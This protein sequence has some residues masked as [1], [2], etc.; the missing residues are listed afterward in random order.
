[1]SLITVQER[2]RLRPVWCTAEGARIAGESYDAVL[3][4]NAHRATGYVDHAGFWFEAPDILVV[5]YPWADVASAG[6]LLD[7]EEGLL[8]SWY[9]EYA[10]GRRE[11]Q[12]LV[13][14]EVEVG[15]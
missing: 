8:E 2:I 11:T 7:S 1:M 9:A 5:Q 4:D 3:H 12:F 10:V 6:A 14:L 15:N 13:E